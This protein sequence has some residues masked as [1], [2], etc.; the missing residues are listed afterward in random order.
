MP[1]ARVHYSYMAGTGE[2][3]DIGTS[4]STSFKKTFSSGEKKKNADF[5]VVNFFCSNFA[6]L[7]MWQVPS[8]NVKNEVITI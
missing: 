2:K 6:P 8:G 4:W 7:K 5:F 1:L 3:G